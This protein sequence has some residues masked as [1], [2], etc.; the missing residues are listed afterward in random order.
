MDA[1]RWRR[2]GE[3]FDQVVEVPAHERD[4]LLRRLCGDDEE[5]LHEV[6]ALLAADAAG[7][8]LDQRT[9]QLRDAVATD[10]AREHESGAPI[11]SMI[12]SWRVLREIGRGG[13]GVVLLVERADGQFEQRAAL[14]LIKRGMDSEAVLARFLRERQILARLA[15][16]GIARLIDGGLSADHRPYFVMEYVQGTSL[17][18]YCL[19]RESGLRER[20]ECI[21]QVCAALQFAHRQLVVHLDIKP[22]NVLV[23][24]NGEIKLLDFGIAKL[25]GGG[26]SDIQTGTG[27]DRPLTPGYASPEQLRSEPVTT[28]TDVYGVGCLLYELLTGRR[29]NGLGDAASLEQVRQA[30]DRG[31]PVAPS[32]AAAGVTNAIAPIP[33]R[34]LR[35]DLDTIV[36]KALKRE[37]ERRYATVE[38]LADDLRR[39]LSGQPIAARRDSALYRIGKFVLRHRVGATLVVAACSALLATTTVALRE[40]Q[41]ARDQAQRAQIQQQE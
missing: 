15:H 20:I 25:L 36:L 40:A 28:A 35:G 21:L 5:L 34:Q 41:S 33:A 31:E 29:P 10:W 14:K 24:D 1:D 2:I 16:P 30:L 11:G 38:S 23:T 13:M 27:H 19:R 32:A 39:H 3:L 6:R 22:S 26:Q 4:G 12:G 17:F 18:D 9:P 8:A 37:P 7:D